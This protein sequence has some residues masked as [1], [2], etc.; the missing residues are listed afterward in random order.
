LRLKKL[1]QEGKIKQFYTELTEIIR[2]YLEGRY[3]VNAME[4]VSTTFRGT[5]LKRDSSGY[6]R[7][8]AGIAAD[9]RPCEV[10]QMGPDATDHDLCFKNAVNLL[11]KQRKSSLMKIKVKNLK[12]SKR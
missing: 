4:M 12:K 7:Q 2:T 10:C 3:E 1:W 8:A 6:A 5:L 9:C 11:K